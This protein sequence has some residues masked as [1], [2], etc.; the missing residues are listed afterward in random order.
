ME[1]M[2]PTKIVLVN[3]RPCLRYFIACL[4]GLFV[5]MEWHLNCLVITKIGTQSYKGIKR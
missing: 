2:T 1:I 4:F 5:R 3:V